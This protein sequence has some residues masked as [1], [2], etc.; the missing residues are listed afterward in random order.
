MGRAAGFR[1]Q[2]FAAE[3]WALAG[4]AD[5]AFCYLQAI[6]LLDSLNIADFSMLRADDDLRSLQT[7]PRWQPAMAQM[8]EKIQKQ[9][10]TIQP[11][12]KIPL[13]D[14]V[15]LNATVYK[16]LVQS[17]PLPVIF[18]LTP[19]LGDSYHDRGIYF[20]KHGYVFIN[21]DVRGRGGSEGDFNPFLNEAK[22]GYDVVEWLA[23]QPYCNGKVTMWG[24]SYGGFDQWAT[25]GGGPPPHLK[26]IV[27]VASVMPGVDYPMQGN[28][29]SPYF[30]RWLT[31]ISGKGSNDKLFDDPS[32]WSSKFYERYYKQIPFALLD[33]VVGYPNRHW[34]TYMAHPTADAFYRQMTPTPVQYS[35]LQL[36]V[37]TITGAYDGNQLGALTY[38]RQFMNYGP[39]V[40]KNQHYL[41]IGPWDHAGT[42]TPKK[43]ENG[44]TMG[45]SSL[46]DLNRLHVEWYDYTLKHGPKP[47]LLRD[48]V[49]YYVAGADRWKSATALEEIGR[50]KSLFY[51]TAFYRDGAGKQDSV[52]LQAAPAATGKPAVYVFNPLDQETGEKLLYSTTPFE[53]ESEV[54]GFFQLDLYVQTDV[55]DVDI[56]AEIGE[57]TKEG[58][59]IPLAAQT[60]RARYRESLLKE[61]LL[62]PGEVVCLHFDCFNFI[63][64]LLAKGSR[65]ALRVYSP[66]SRWDQVNYGSGGP[67]AYETAKDAHTATIKIYNDKEHA[68]VLAV[69]IIK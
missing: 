24:G 65:L 66:N 31:L 52:S 61:K 36:P 11:T 19:Y 28:I 42:R 37:L 34:K 25:A 49:V 22:D 16:P 2:W 39:P 67:V 29:V 53:Q 47:A 60:V 35:K 41:I 21:V 58:K 14:G 5:S 20:A 26:T 7:D 62:V 51:L 12:I 33:S 56:R 4:S 46:L 63:S 43:V 59:W 69:P 44:V 8:W 68:S 30:T 64:R 23:R 13:H 48:K 17:A 27:P 6:L 9:E 18:T 45:D 50:E 55:R 10:I 15:H 3:A 38:Y 57:R 1:P 40:G 32:Y 54:S